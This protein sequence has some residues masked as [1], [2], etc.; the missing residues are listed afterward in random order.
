MLQITPA[1]RRH[2]RGLAHS[3]NP[4]VMIGQHGLTPAVIRETAQSLAHHE[5]IKMSYGDYVRLVR[6]V[7]AKISTPRTAVV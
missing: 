6:P 1:Q 3:L 2:L 4:V 5:L 7:V